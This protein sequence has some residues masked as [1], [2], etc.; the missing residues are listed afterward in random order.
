M[1]LVQILLVIRVFVILL[2]NFSHELVQ[3]IAWSVF[4]V[5]QHRVSLCGFDANLSI[6]IIV[7]QVLVWSNFIVVLKGVY[8]V[9]SLW[10]FFNIIDELVLLRII[11]LHA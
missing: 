5:H 10:N 6:I 11:V 3:C 8:V 9:A 2:R 1:L 7:V 4:A